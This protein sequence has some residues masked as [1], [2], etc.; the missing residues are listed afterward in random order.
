M[1]KKN[2]KMGHWA[3]ML[4]IA[5]AIVGA[6]IG[7]YANEITFL[8]IV[9]G[10]IVGFMNITQKEVSG[11]LLAV[12]AL[13]MVGAAGLENIP[14]IGGTV[15]VILGNISA[16]VAPAAVIVALKAVWEMGK[17]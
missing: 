13:L 10:L 2:S 14:I 8:L 1:K 3:F 16:F 17:K 6:L 7:M 5:I 15:G 4:G 9:L 11:F 12:I